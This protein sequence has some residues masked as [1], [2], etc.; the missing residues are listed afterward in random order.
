ML[1]F[2]Y[3]LI[4]HLIGDFL[5][6]TSYVFK[7]KVKSS[8]GILC[9]V[10]FVFLATVIV[11]IPYLNNSEIWI[12]LIVNAI[13][14]FILDY[15]KV[16]YD[17]KHKAKNPIALFWIDQFIHILIILCI[18]Q[19]IPPN[20][21]PAYFI[22]TWW[23]EY[24]QQPKILIYILGFLFFSY[25]ADIVIFTHRTNEKRIATYSRSYYSMIVR[26]FLFACLFIMFWTIARFYLH[27]F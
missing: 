1:F 3:F 27:L 21:T 11:F 8:W 13:L 24:W 23:F 10:S 14:H 12:A 4:G 17:K 5:L 26:T 2:F 19:F 22:D 18:L 6:Q 20:I 15:S 16:K 9:H 7:W 25:M